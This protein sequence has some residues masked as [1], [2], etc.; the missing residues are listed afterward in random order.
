MFYQIL[1]YP[2]APEKSP[3]TN[4]LARGRGDAWAARRGCHGSQ[5]EGRSLSPGAPGHGLS[6]GPRRGEALQLEQQNGMV[7]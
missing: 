6:G 4:G 2:S 7:H 1:L 5:A 3:E